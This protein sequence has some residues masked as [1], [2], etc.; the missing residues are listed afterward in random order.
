MQAEEKLDCRVHKPEISND[1]MCALH[2]K[3]LGLYQFSRIEH[4]NTDPRLVTALVE[5]WRPETHTFHLSVGETTLTL[6]DVSCLWGLPIS[7][8]VVVD[9]SV[10]D[11]YDLIERC[12][13]PGK[14]DQVI[15]SRRVRGEIVQSEGQ[16]LLHY[17]RTN[18]NPLGEDATAEEIERYTRAY[19]MDL[20]GSVLFPNCSG[21]GVPAMYLRFLDDLEPERVPNWGAVALA[22]LYRFVFFLFYALQS[23]LSCVP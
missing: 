7:G 13:G 12:F 20:F 19:I 23:L 15:Y 2:L 5:R 11:M 3:N 8:D 18:T 10:N 1:D 17:L 21:D 4:V 6:E 16:I 9:D 14:A 22:C